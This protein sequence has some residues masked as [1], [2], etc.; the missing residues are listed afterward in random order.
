[1]SQ[2]RTTTDHDEI[3]EWAEQRGGKPSTVRATADEDEA[4]ILRLDFPPED[5][6]LEQISWEAFFEKF[7]EAKLAF[8]FQDET[9][10]KKQSRF[11]KFVRRQ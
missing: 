7:E 5:D 8:L 3:R 10:D 2:A 1:M 11:H 9:G 6:A 4:G